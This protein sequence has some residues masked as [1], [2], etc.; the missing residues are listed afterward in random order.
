MFVAG[1]NESANS[2]EVGPDCVALV[3]SS[4]LLGRAQYMQPVLLL[5]AMRAL[6]QLSESSYR[7]E[8]ESFSKF[9]SEHNTLKTLTKI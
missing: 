5:N 9:S 4:G 7:F 3:M 1:A 8:L 2:L 6:V